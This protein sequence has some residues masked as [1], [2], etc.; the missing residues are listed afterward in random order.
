MLRACIPKYHILID[1]FQHNSRNFYQKFTNPIPW[2]QLH[3]NEPSNNE[4]LFIFPMLLLIPIRCEAKLGQ[5]RVYITLFGND[6]SEA[7]TG[8]H[9]SLSI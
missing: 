9:L 7:L 4:R 3:S 5:G 6:R 8:Y 1:P 2:F